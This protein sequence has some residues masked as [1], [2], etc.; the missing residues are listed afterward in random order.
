MCNFFFLRL[1]LSNKSERIL[2]NRFPLRKLVFVQWTIFSFFGKE[3]SILQVKSL[4][5]TSL[6]LKFHILYSLVQLFEASKFIY[7]GLFNKL[8]I[9]NQISA[10]FLSLYP[11]MK[12]IPSNN[13]SQYRLWN[14][15]FPP[16][17]N[18]ILSKETIADY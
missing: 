16:E 17:K 13:S 18:N 6:I 15:F 4:A 14:F 7:F 10:L 3:L 1:Y 12:I 8:T 9:F 5:W 2:E 11:L